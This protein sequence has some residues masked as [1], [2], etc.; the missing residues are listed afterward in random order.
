MI[1]PITE[2]AGHVSALG[3]RVPVDLGGVAELKRRCLETL[4]RLKDPP[5][6]IWFRLPADATES[7]DPSLLQGD[8]ANAPALSAAPLPGLAR[9]VARDAEPPLAATRPAASQGQRQ[10]RGRR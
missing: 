3:H 2:Q 10:G 1:I 5:D 7:P 4:C 6:R 9:A 8:D